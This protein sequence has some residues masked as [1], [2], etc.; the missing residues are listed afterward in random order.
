MKI[1]LDGKSRK[2]VAQLYL[3]FS[4]EMRIYGQGFVQ[5]EFLYG[6]FDELFRAAACCILLHTAKINS[7]SGPCVAFLRLARRPVFVLPARQTEK[8]CHVN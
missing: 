3:L 6:I 1:Y 7:L 8:N 2:R 5:S 4:W